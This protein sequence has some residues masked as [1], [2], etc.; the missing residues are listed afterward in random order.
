[1]KTL[2]LAWQNPVS[3]AWFPIGRLF[4]DGKRY[5][6]VYTQGVIAAQQE[7]GFQLLPSFPDLDKVY[8]SPELFPLFANRLLRRSRPDYTDFMQW[9]NL[10]IDEDNP[11]A[12]L[13]RSGGQRVTDNLAVFPYLEPDENGVYHL[14]FFAQGLLNLP[15]ETG[16]RI[17]CLQTGEA[18]HLVCSTNSHALRTEDGYLVGYCPR[19]LLDNLLEVL[20]QY[21][22]QVKVKVDRV[23]PPPTPLQ[24][25]LLCHLKADLPSGFYPFSNAMY[26]PVKYLAIEL[27]EPLQQALATCF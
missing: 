25:R 7:C 19:Y 2:F 18:L 1:M 15:P 24:L 27:P 16:D 5:Q 21:P 12:I 6:F 4:F 20:R 10:P 8:E 22:E 14:R 17:S 26:Q 23:N 3:D 9:L 11:I 13:A